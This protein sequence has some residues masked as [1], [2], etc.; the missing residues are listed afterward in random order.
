VD[1]NPPSGQVQPITVDC[2]DD[3]PAPDVTQVTN[4]DDNCRIPCVTE[5]WINEFHYDNIGTDVNEFIEVAGPAGIDLS[6][7]T[8]YVYDGFNG[9]FYNTFNLSGIIPDEDNGFGAGFVLTPNLQNTTEGIAL[10]KNGTEVIEFISYEGVVTA[11]NGPANGMTSVDVGVAESN[12]VTP[13]N[14]SLGRI[15]NGNKPGDFTWA[16]L[17]QTQGT[18]NTGQT[19]SDCPDNEP[20]VTFV[21]DVITS[22]G[23][24]SA[25]DPYVVTRTYRITDAA[26]NL[27]DVFQTITAN[28]CCP[29][30]SDNIAYVNLNA[31]TGAN[32][33]T[34]WDDAFTD[35]Q[36]ALNSICPGI[37]EI[38]VAA[39][40][41]YPTPGT[42]RNATF[43]LKNNLAIFGGFAGTEDPLTFNLADRNFMANVTTLSGD[44]GATG[45]NSDN[46]YTVVT[47]SGTNNTAVID[48]FTITGGNA[49]TTGYNATGLGGG[50]YNSAGSP[51]ITNCTFSGN[52][53]TD[54]GGM[55]N[56]DASPTVTNCTFSVNSGNGMSN[57]NSP[58]TV[59]N[60]TFSG[61]SGRGMTNLSC[62]P[63]VTNSI[64][65]G[66]TTSSRG[67]GMYNNYYSS[68]TV[69]NCTFSGNTANNGGG[70]ANNYY[71]SP[72]IKN[73]IIWGN[74]SGIYNSESTP[75]VSFSIVQ[76][77]YPGNLNADPIF[78]NPGGGDLRLQACSPAINVG[79]NA[80]VP[81]GITTDLDG[82]P[83]IYDNGIVDMGAYE[84]QGTAFS[85]PVVFVKNNATGANNG[86]SWDDAFI[87]LQDALN[88]SCPGVNQI[89]VAAGTYYPDEG[90]GYTDNDRT[91]S[92]V[93]KNNLAIY[94]GFAGTED[95][96]T[97]DL[98]DRDFVA[99]ET[100][101]SGDIDQN[102]LLDAGNSYHVV[103]G[104]GTNMTAL[105]DGF[106]I[107]R[108][109]A[110]GATVPANYGAGMYIDAG[111]PV[112]AN[113][114][115]YQNV[116]TANGGG[117][118][119]TGFNSE[120]V[121]K[122]CR[123]FANNA[124]YGG[125]IYID[126][127][128]NFTVV[129][130]SFTSNMAFEDGG[131][132]YLDGNFTNPPELIN[133]TFY[134]NSASRG[135]A[136]FHDN[137]SA[138]ITNSIFFGNTASEGPVFYTYWSNPATETPTTSYTLVDVANCAALNVFA[139]GTCVDAT[140][141][142]SS[143]PLFVDADGADNT[144]GTSD[145]DLRLLSCS[146][147]I[148]AGNNAAVPGGITTDL[149]GNPRIY[150]NGV[151]D[152]GAY[153]LQ[154]EKNVNP[155]DGGE[156][157]SS[158]AVCYNVSP[159]PFTSPSLPTGHTGTLEYQWQKSTTS[160]VAGFADISGADAATYD[161]TATI[162]QTTWYRRLAKVSCETLW[163]ESNVVEVSL[164][165]LPPVANCQNLT[166]PLGDMG[167]INLS[168]EDVNNNSTAS[169]GEVTL[170][171]V[172]PN[173]FDCGDIGQHSVI[174]TV[175]DS[176]GNTASCTATVTVNDPFGNCCAN[177]TDG[178]EIAADQDI[179]S[180][181]GI[182]P[183]TSTT[184][185]TGH[186]GTLEYQWQK[187][188]TSAAADFADINGAD[189]ATYTETA[190]LTQTTWYRRMAK[191][192]CETEWVESNV[193]QV[194]VNPRPANPT[195]S[196]PISACEGTNVI[197]SATGSGTGDLVFFNNTFTEIAR[198]TMGGEPT[199]TFNAGAKAAGSYTYYAAEDDGNCSSNPVAID[200]TV[201]P[202]PAA[203]TAAGAT[204]CEGE[205]A[206]LTAVASGTANWYS[207]AALTNLVATGPVYTTITLTTT[208]D[209]Y[210]TNSDA[211]DCESLSI[212][213][214][215]AVEP[216]PVSGTLTK[217]PD[218]T[219]VCEGDDVS[220]ILTAGTGGNGTD[221]LELRTHDESTWSGWAN[222]TSG[223]I[224]ST[225]GLTEV[226]IRTRRTAD[227]CTASD[228]ETVSWTIL[229]ISNLTVRVNITASKAPNGQ[230]K[231]KAVPVN[232]GANPTYI[233]YKNGVEI[234]GVTGDELITTCKAGDEHW[235]VLTSSIPCTAPAESNTMCTY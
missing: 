103:I 157:A 234:D 197:I 78:V 132:M 130:S 10:V 225:S 149:D 200:V 109:F 88:S 158:Q 208:T 82:N 108:G 70:I 73:C 192:T 122:N 179:C 101:L 74:N 230:V 144:I 133:N 6:I 90:N 175:S 202:L 100:I 169:C 48:G 207:D 190:T 115:F 3:I 220:A 13:A 63:T 224:V 186:T 219:N 215:V 98:A 193:V 198:Y 105:L 43:Q 187:S 131:A 65:T 163:V 60:C 31:T 102:N 4:V 223:D 195:V 47:G 16:V 159:D 191:V 1:S 34:S 116:A 152:M 117:L 93:M 23:A 196:S 145:D 135:G 127:L 232:G 21:E 51:R 81:G 206:V 173:Y 66:N 92:F 126:N 40:T 17:T 104:S 114:T 9:E 203:P 189:A 139:G 212:T 125:G 58:V 75:N 57:D 205:S 76:G 95:P 217:T 96:L 199:Q 147:A 141:I 140:M 111:S 142:Y 176:Q 27:V 214:T 162:I 84:Y 165:D 45:N 136:M 33:G 94:G 56:L 39:G 121:V 231:F 194:V 209:Y 12:D 151:V 150:D 211:N 97:F 228:Y 85:G 222:Y 184:L 153:E 164:V 62:S 204:I 188:T 72:S 171:S 213:V 148:N 15:G 37:T 36:D 134:A 123:F 137:S 64:F 112:V 91:H 229:E 174:L 35:L 128:T 18:L 32:N 61:N 50:M 167:Y 11:T 226:E 44:I 129:N 25:G 138:N 79:N 180:G 59:T 227:Y 53:A 80:A 155:T 154:G 156:I 107:T 178:G 67:G 185:P 71:S 110:N 183:F 221:E 119:A 201:N 106:S 14:G 38:W 28:N 52:S 19:I 161:E 118:A 22:P 177:P 210:V 8:L 168:P 41:Y 30:Y 99:N 235:V 55:F 46:S 77:G 181:N 124:P 146:P 143:D 160:A 83:R 68:P 216:T 26:G 218:A 170:V 29:T 2:P 54:G 113:N 89:W 233:W 172:V 86:F 49:N 24:G 20:V 120:P 69:T 42:D 166:I 5:P 7:Y 182:N 87:N